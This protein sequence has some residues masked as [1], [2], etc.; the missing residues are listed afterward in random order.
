MAEVQPV[1][2]QT[3]ERLPEP[4]APPVPPAPTALPEPPELLA[5]QIQPA[6]PIDDDVPLTKLDEL[7]ER[8]ETMASEPAAPAFE[9]PRLKVPEP[10]PV[11]AEP[12]DFAS[13]LDDRASS[14]DE[15]VDYASE[16]DLDVLSAAV[17][18]LGRNKPAERPAEREIPPTEEM[19][20]VEQGDV[21][22]KPEADLP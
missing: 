9:M 14:P 3:P 7:V 8:A 6:L 1:V 17:A 4:P 21:E 11:L 13:A 18:A 5:T 22:P 19:S 20:A 12:F 10:I 2:V 15:P 16:V